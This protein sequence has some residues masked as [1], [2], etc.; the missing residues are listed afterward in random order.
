MGNM[1]A[2]AILA[3]ILA[4]TTTITA[5]GHCEGDNFFEVDG[6]CYFYLTGSYNL[7]TARAE[8]AAAD[9][10]L[11]PVKNSQ[12]F[13][14]AKGV[15]A[16]SYNFGDMNYAVFWVDQKFDYDTRELVCCD[17][18][19][20][21]ENTIKAMSM[22]YKG[23]PCF[24]RSTTDM[25]LVFRSGV[26]LVENPVMEFTKDSTPYKQHPAGMHC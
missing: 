3:F 9:G 15:V 21:A 13:E 4:T 12:V 11:A 1:N 25:V 16:A 7:E 17:G 8:C 18:E 6:T 20:I 22:W 24:T 2:I 19:R 14:A 10:A 26:S 5:D 23:Q